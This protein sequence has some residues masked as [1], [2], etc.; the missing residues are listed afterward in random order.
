MVLL[1]ACA[2]VA[3]LA[4]ARATARQKEIAVRLSLG[5]QRWSIARQFLTE[6]LVLSLAGGAAGLVLAVWGV[7]GAEG[8]APLAF[9]RLRKGSASTL[10]CCCSR[11]ESQFSRDC[12]SESPPP[13]Q[14][15]AAT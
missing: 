6:S 14:P 15:R 1:I 11:S 2:N 3:N 10:R 8:D 4:L 13:I 9:D 5:A 12:C 7:Q